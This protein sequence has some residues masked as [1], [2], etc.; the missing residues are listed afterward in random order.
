MRLSI[1]VAANVCLGVALVGLCMT[2]TSGKVQSTIVRSGAPVQMKVAPKTTVRSAMRKVSRAHP[3]KFNAL[4]NAGTIMH[5][6]AETDGEFNL[7]KMTQETACV[8]GVKA[9]CNVEWYGENRPKYLG[10]FQSYTPAYLTGEFPGD[11]GWDS[12][13]LSAD[14]VTF[15]G[16]RE[17][18]VIHGRWAMLGALGCL[19]PELLNKAGFNLPVWFKAGGTI[20]DQGID[21]LGNPNLVH[22][23]SAMAVLATQVVLMGA[24]EAYRFNGGP[25]G[26]VQDAIYPGGALDPL[27]F[28]KD[29]SKAAELKVKEIKNGRLAMTAMLG[30]YVQ[31]IATG[32]G[33]LEN[34]SEHIADPTHVNGFAFATQFTPQ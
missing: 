20:F 15:K 30:Y 4:V 3:E 2:S 17:T 24:S 31:A 12:A 32:K 13:G 19:F 29:P 33:P 18:E 34:W 1:S 21:Y 10:P 7:D 9:A 25:L 11:Y 16:Y 26:D 6:I 14:P 28:A 27:G 23:Q 5:K 22:A 8:M